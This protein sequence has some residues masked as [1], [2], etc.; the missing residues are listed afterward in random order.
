[1]ELIAV[2]DKDTRQFTV[3]PNSNEV[4]RE[5]TVDLSKV[6]NITPFTLDRLLTSN[7]YE[8]PDGEDWFEDSIM[9]LTFPVGR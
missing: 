5:L 8:R 7:G 2:F 9:L 4:E 6:P 3:G 1:M